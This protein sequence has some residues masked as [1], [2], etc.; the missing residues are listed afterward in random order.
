V[1]GPRK[2][3]ERLSPEEKA[4]IVRLRIEERKSSL[5]IAK[6]MRSN[7]TTICAIIK[8]FP[9]TAEEMAPR[10]AVGFKTGR[11]T[12]ARTRRYTGGTE[13]SAEEE[14]ALQH[15][16]PSYPKDRV[17]AALPGRTWAT[18]AKRASD[19]GLRRSR[20]ASFGSA[21]RRR[22][23]PIFKSLRL[24]REMRGILQSE[25]AERIGV[26]KG[27]FLNLEN[28]HARPTWL[29][30]RD[31]LTALQCDIK[32]LQLNTAA[33]TRGK[34]PWLTEEENILRELSAQGSTVE[35]MAL[36]LKR[37]AGELAKRLRMLG[38][39]ENDATASVSGI[40]K[41]RSA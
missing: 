9:L 7:T 21:K 36:A 20:T 23:D 19:Q 1:N 13:W 8:P 24:I 37:P 39:S 2:R 40:T 27:S 28:G 12:L 10:K 35:E 41:R 25:L 4:E 3:R 5:E 16:W 32:I 38:L 29:R 30:M 18:I 34:R 17:L 6:I 11:Q 31:W 14:H 22:I 33:S 15:F 26:T